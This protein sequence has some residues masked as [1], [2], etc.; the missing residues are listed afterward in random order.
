MVG[1]SKWMPTG[2][3]GWV[4]LPRRAAAEVCL[5]HGFQNN[6]GVTYRIS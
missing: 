2:Y 3:R 5:L 6:G 4:D 1:L